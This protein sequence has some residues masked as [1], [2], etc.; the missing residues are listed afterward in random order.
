MFRKMKY[1]VNITLKHLVFGYKTFDKDYI[2]FNYFLTISFFTI[3]KA[4]YMYVSEQQK[5]INVYSLSLQ[6]LNTRIEV[7]VA[8][9]NLS[10]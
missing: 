4:Y 5:Y 6:E 1:E 2:D 9:V 10:T 3:Y 7:M 8:T